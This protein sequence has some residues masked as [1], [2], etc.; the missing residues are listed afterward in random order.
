LNEN[1]K[2]LKYLIKNMENDNEEEKE[3][4]SEDITD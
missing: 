4:K 3:K 2:D 1:I